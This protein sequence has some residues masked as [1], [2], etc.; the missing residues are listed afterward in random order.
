MF[1]SAVSRMEVEPIL[2]SIP[3]ACQYLSCNSQVIYKLA[4]TGQLE[5]VK[6]GGRTLIVFSSVK[7][8]AASLPKAQLTPPRERLPKRLRESKGEKE[9]GAP[10]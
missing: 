5:A 6:R 4:A 1:P 3:Q 10:A 8:Y 9:A 2:V 7:R